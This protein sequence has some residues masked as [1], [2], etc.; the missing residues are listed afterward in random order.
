MVQHQGTNEEGGSNNERLDKTHPGLRIL[1][2]GAYSKW[3][4]V[5]RSE[6]EHSARAR[7]IRAHLVDLESYLTFGMVTGSPDFENVYQRC[8]YSH[9]R[10]GTI[11]EYPCHGATLK[12][13]ELGNVNK[14]I[15]NYGPVF[16]KL[17]AVIV[18]ARYQ[19]HATVV[20]VYT[21]NG[22]GITFLS[23]EEKKEHVLLLDEG[24]QK[25]VKAEAK[26]RAKDKAKAKAADEGGPETIFAI[27]DKGFT[28]NRWFN[29]TTY[30]KFTELSSHHYKM[31]CRLLG[32]LDRKSLDKL[33]NI[34][35]RR[36]NKN[37]VEF[38]P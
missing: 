32:K 37:S 16:T 26:A 23:K 11:I 10:P 22:K 3:L 17:R 18:V 36:F 35:L 27:K 15:S 1:K 19:K 29:T 38:A 25:N 2:E 8:D 13:I 28:G 14:S 21:H 4:G 6:G 5:K 20:P 31:G 30:V 24:E 7:L 34:I 33:H 12:P 9:H